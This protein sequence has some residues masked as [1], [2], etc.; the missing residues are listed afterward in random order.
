MTDTMTV[1]NRT[2]VRQR[3][4]RHAATLHDFD[5]LLR[6][7]AERLT[8]R[9]DDVMRSFPLALDLGCRGGILGRALAGRGGIET[10][11]QSDLS[12]AMASQA[13][14]LGPTFV[15]DEEALPI[16]DRS[17]DLVMS[18]LSL[19]WVND[20]PGALVQVQQAL[21]AD[22]LLLAALFGGETLFELRDS[23]ASAEMELEGGMS[24]RVSPFADIRDLGSLM[25]RAGFALPVIDTETITVSYAEPLS[26]MRD[27]RGMAESN[28][29][30]ARRKTPLRRST[31]VRACEIY[32]QKYGGP[33]GQI[34]ATFQVM[35]LTGWAPDANQPQPLKPGQAT[36]RLSDVLNAEEGAFDEKA[37]PMASGITSGIAPTRKPE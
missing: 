17:L 12:S 32:Q 9:L 14:V 18:S 22:G 36:T 6:D 5:F 7:V 21:K 10:L 1:F 8:D 23:L 29:V 2:L 20:L 11:L 24:P 4:N 25:Q 16:A 26:L 15:G 35:M 31:L 30:L 19:H 3:R 37:M 34:P 33:D 27:L 28:T 13:L